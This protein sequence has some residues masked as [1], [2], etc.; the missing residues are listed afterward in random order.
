MFN[1]DPMELLLTLP[2]II[3]GFAFHEFSHAFAAVRL[4]DI[5]PEEQGRLTIAPL[6]HVDIIGLLLMMITGGFGWAKPVQIERRNFKN[7]RQD[8]IMVALAGPMMNLAI[9]FLFSI[10]LK[11]FFVTGLL[12]Q[13]SQTIAAGITSITQRIVWINLVLFTFNLLPIYPLDGFYLLSSLA[14]YSNFNRLNRLRYLSRFI[15]IIIIITPAASYIITPIVTSIYNGLFA[16][17]VL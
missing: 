11:I 4:G 1:I 16:L 14:H 2:G 8:E 9:A 3:I 5:T 17:L 10:L 7:P 12:N 15:L 6:P 13:T